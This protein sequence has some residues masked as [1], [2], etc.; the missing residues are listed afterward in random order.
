MRLYLCCQ[1][2]EREMSSTIFFSEF[3]TNMYMVGGN[4][5]ESVGNENVKS[6]YMMSKHV[7]ELSCLKL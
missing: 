6:M 1:V 7:H 2:K 4:V 5:D 3:S